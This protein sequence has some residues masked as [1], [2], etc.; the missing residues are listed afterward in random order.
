M[1]PHHSLTLTESEWVRENAQRYYEPPP[2]APQ[3][4]MQ[5]G[6]AGM[7]WKHDLGYQAP[8]HTTIPEPAEATLWERNTTD[9]RHTG[10]QTPPPQH[11]RYRTP[12]P[13]YPHGCH[14]CG[15]HNHQQKRYRYDHRVRCAIC[16]QLGH[17]QRLCKY[18]RQ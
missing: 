1:R 7:K 10:T 6:P 17:R 3:H 9:A 8:R 4:S 16:H 18:Y 12:R 11:S 5:R 14:N 15:E 2:R 13:S